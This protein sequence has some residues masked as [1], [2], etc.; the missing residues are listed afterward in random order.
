M[1][2]YGIMQ[3]LS[4]LFDTETAILEMAMVRYFM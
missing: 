2:K 1:V 3:T 4:G